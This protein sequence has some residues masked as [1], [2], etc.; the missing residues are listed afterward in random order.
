[1][2]LMSVFKKDFM[3]IQ[4]FNFKFDSDLKATNKL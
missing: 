2:K 3:S 1:V 4:I